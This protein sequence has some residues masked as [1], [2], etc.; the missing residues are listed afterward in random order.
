MERRR[1]RTWV[2]RLAGLACYLIG[3]MDI[4]GAIFH[5]FR[6]HVHPLA[7]VVPG[8]VTS[9]A[10]AGTIIAGVLLLLLAKAL[11]RRK[12][13]AWRAVVALLAL[14]V[15]LHVVRGQGLIDALV[16]GILLAILIKNR[17]E[18]Y[19]L[20]DPRTRWR[21]VGVFVLLSAV[22]VLLGL[23]IVAAAHP[24]VTATFQARVEHVLYG[25]VGFPGPLDFRTER[26]DHFVAITLFGLGLLTAV[27]TAYLALR[28]AEP[29]PYLTP[30]D[31]ERVR[32]LLATPHGARD[33]L[34]YFALRHD[35][36]VIW[37]PTG[38][39]CVAYRVVSG[40][41]LASGDPLGD[42]EAWPGAI[43]RFM[44]EADRHA[45]VPAV[46][47]C[48]EL[49]GEI[50]CREAGL[51]AL[52]LGDEAVVDVTAFSLQGRSMRNVR[53]MVNRI[54]RQGYSCQMRR[55]REIPPEERAELARLA[56]SWR[57]GETERGFSMALGRIGGATDGECVVVTA[58]KDGAV[59]GLLQFVPWGPDGLSLD[60][61]RRDRDADPGVNELMIVHALR[62]ASSLGVRRISLN[63]AV[64]RSAL[65][66]G[67]RL[68]AWPLLRLCRKIL[69]FLS[70]WFQIESLY[71]FNA[72]FQPA[73]QPRYLVYPSA[74]DL[75]RIVLAILEA[76]AFL[77]P[78]KPWR[79]R[80]RPRVE[81]EPVPAHP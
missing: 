21:A 2:P 11:R 80:A 76:E 34:G 30:E 39:S 38:K 65:A 22:S 13:R 71:K 66:R 33:S 51:D 47:G 54:E 40:V 25:L 23:V 19:A 12:R 14:S 1:R 49:G 74:G 36:S 17:K 27:T 15:V 16:S 44:Q 4:A 43:Q 52:E 42:Y 10:A 61:M 70:R 26:G 41:M 75:P 79:R 7:Q 20:G 58:C 46:M 68:G 56:D 53:Q 9:A 31:E 24:P 29:R 48:S 73:W 32:K 50:W 63:F 37:S 5:R 77:V 59:R 18:F 64:F 57:S 67:E 60:L 78:P 6:A 62:E 35:K 45:W 81:R 3:F 69:L 72:K 8:V 55:V 28:P